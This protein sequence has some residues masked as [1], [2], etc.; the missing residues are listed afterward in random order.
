M[1]KVKDFYQRIDLLDECFRQHGKKWTMKQL[2]ERVNALHREHRASGKA[3]D[4]DDWNGAYTDFDR[5]FENGRNAHRL[6]SPM[7]HQQ[8]IQTFKQ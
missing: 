2:L 3:G 4:A 5:L 8:P 6:L 1:P 7:S